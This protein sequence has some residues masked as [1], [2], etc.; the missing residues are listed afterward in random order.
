MSSFYIPTNDPGS[1]AYQNFPDVIRGTT[2]DGFLRRD[3]FV[4][5]T[6]RR[7]IT[8][9]S[10]YSTT[11]GTATLVYQGY[12]KLSALATGKF[13]IV[14][15]AEKGTVTVSLGGS[16]THVYGTTAAGYAQLVTTA[17]TPGAWVPFLITVTKTVGQP[18]VNLYGLSIYEER[19][20][21]PSLP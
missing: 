3:R 9:V 8:T 17:L 12:A 15:Y 4:Y 10:N 1:P 14:G 13:W 5:A 11:S 16:W 18:Y 6:S 21:E 7:L 20:P 2:V 19:L